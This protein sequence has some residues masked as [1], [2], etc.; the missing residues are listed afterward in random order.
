[1]ESRDDIDAWADSLLDAHREYPRGAA[2][3]R[4][5]TPEQLARLSPISRWALTRGANVPD[6]DRVDKIIR[7]GERHRRFAAAEAAV[8][9]VGTVL[10]L[11]FALVVLG[12]F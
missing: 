9:A 12:M 6:A 11:I 10:A 1:V 4:P 5:A 7:A 8:T 2:K 3:P